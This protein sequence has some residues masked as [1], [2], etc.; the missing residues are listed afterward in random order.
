MVSEHINPLPEGEAVS[1]TAVTLTRLAVGTP[2]NRRPLHSPGRA[3]L[4]HPVPRS[5]SLSRKTRSSYRH[6]PG[7]SQ[8]D[9]GLPE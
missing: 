4:P 7:R 9:A 2:G 8:H 3:V 1:G 6:P 5:H